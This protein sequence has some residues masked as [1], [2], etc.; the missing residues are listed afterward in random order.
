MAASKILIIDDDTDDVEILTDA[1]KRTG[2]ESVHYVH[3]AMQAFMYLQKFKSIEELPKL[4]VTD[5]FL[6]SISGAEFLA[7]LREME[8]YKHIH[9]IVLS[10]TKSDKEI[11]RYRL[12]VRLTTWLN[13]TLM[14]NM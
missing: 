1:F 11:E 3:T 6:P 13:P 9:V 10:T 14:R 2:V 8:L 5:S 12:R 4:I 7:D